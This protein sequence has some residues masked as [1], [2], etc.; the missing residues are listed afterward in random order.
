MKAGEAEASSL[1]GGEQALIGAFV[2]LGFG[3]TLGEPEGIPDL[4]KALRLLSKVLV[5]QRLLAD[6]R[7]A[8]RGATDDLGRGAGVLEVGQ[9][10][11]T[12]AVGRMHACVVSVNGLG[13]IEVPVLKVA[14]V[15]EALQ[16]GRTDRLACSQ[17]PLPWG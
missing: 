6:S 9:E 7:L 4:G 8:G 17:A 16:V 2:V 13:E 11:G 15:K 1:A 12:V 3:T 14:F 5:G 10:V